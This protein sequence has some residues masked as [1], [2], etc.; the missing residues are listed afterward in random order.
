MTEEQQKSLSTEVKKPDALTALLKQDSVRK[1]FEDVLGK[2]AAGFMSSIISATSAN[3][4]LKNADPLSIVQAAAVAAALDLPINPSLGFA[5][6]VPYKKDG[7]P[8]AQF[9]MGWKGFVQLGMRTGQYR[10]I[11]VSIVYEG[12]L[13]SRN[14]FT[15]EIEF[16]ETKRTSD[17]IAG[18]VAYFKLINGFEK[19]FYMTAAEAKA[20]GKRYSQSFNNANSRW[21]KDFDAMAMKTV[22]KMLL[23]KWGI[24]SIE[25]QTAIQADQSVVK[26]EGK[27]EYPDGTGEIIDGEISEPPKTTA[28]ELQE[29]FG[30]KADPPQTAPAPCPDSPETTYLKEH[31]DKCG[32]REGCPA[33][34]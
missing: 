23:S 13:V 5:H 15:G 6:I 24:L 10:T 30:K 8:V 9:Q 3:K 34:S 4:E 22:I 31:C 26:G 7:T 17:K 32:K 11:N 21:Q 1:R 18:Y 14:R 25:M 33:W 29:R 28:H 19:W 20:H 2:K 27:Y 16:D 12:E